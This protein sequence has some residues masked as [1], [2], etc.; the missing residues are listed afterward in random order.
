MRFAVQ[1]LWP[2]LR[3]SATA[4]A[5]KTNQ[6]PGTNVQ[7]EIEDMISFRFALQAGRA[8]V[9][10]ECLCACWSVNLQLCSR[11]IVVLTELSCGGRDICCAFTAQR[12]SSQILLRVTLGY[13]YKRKI[14]CNAWQRFGVSSWGYGMHIDCLNVLSAFRCLW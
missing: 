14:G 5:R 11:K 1:S 12:I 3:T 9:L 8:R 7:G 13:F 2:P 10:K 4:L 6:A